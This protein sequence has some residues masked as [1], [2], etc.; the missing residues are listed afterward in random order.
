MIDAYNGLYSSIKSQHYENNGS[1]LCGKVKFIVNKDLPTIYYCHCSLCRKQSGTG[2]NSAALVKDTLFEWVSSIDSIATFKKESGFTSCFCKN[3]GSPVP[4]PVGNTSFIWIPLGLL[5][6][7]PV[8][9]KNLSFCLNS[10]ISW[11][12]V[13]AVD[14]EYLELPNWNELED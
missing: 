7:T 10:K 1:C 3:C 13:I 5:N 2:E 12:P 6:D 4:N 9:Q 11:V 14:Q 8:F